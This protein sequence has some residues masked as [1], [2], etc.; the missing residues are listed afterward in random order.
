MT[1]SEW[2]MLQEYAAQQGVTAVAFAGLEHSTALPPMDQLM[3][4]L[5]QAEYV[6]SHYEIHKNGLNQMDNL[7]REV[8]AN[9]LVLKGLSLVDYFPTPQSREFGDLDIYTFNDT[10]TAHDALNK[11]IE[12]KGIKI[13]YWDRHDV[14]NCGDT[15]VEHHSYFLPK[16]SKTGRYINE[17]LKDIAHKHSIHID[18]NTYYPNPDFNSLYLLNHTIGHMSYE[19]ATL[20]N[21]LDYGLFLRKD[22]DKVN[23]DVVRPLMLETGWVVGFNTLI[24][25]AEKVLAEDLSRFYIGTPNEPL[26]GKVLNTILD[27][28]LHQEADLPLLKR[29]YAKWQRLYSHKWMYDSGLIPANFWTDCVWGSFKEHIV[30]P[31]QF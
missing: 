26:V 19:G 24:R 5:G 6:K 25:V 8:N 14:F 20:K 10:G 12:Q 30:R 18:S 9:M 22:G 31:E 11:Q 2:I 29:V 4:W 1:I 23:W 13:E 28:T 15:H 16:R 3:D 17:V 27:T 21:V 7:C